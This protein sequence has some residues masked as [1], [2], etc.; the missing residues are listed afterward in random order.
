[1]PTQPQRLARR[2]IYQNHWVNLFID[3]VEFPDGRI[4]EEHHFL[5]FEREAAAA[6]VC[7]EN[8]ALLMVEAYR[9]ITDSIGWEI[10][11]GSIDP[12]EEICAAAAREV[13]EETGYTTSGH[14]HF[15]S[16][17]PMNGIANARF[18]LVRCEAGSTVAAFDRNEVRSVRWFTPAELQALIDTGQ[19]RDGYSLTGVLMHLNQL[20]RTTDYSPPAG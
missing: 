5:D 13:L 20:A 14:A 15:Y 8:G 6:L 16:F 1:M 12:D 10:P 9:Y 19:M 18:H 2:V 3:R 4:I 7:R 11:A 17:N